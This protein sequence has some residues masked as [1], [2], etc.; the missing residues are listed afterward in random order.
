MKTGKEKSTMQAFD[1][2]AIHS[3]TAKRDGHGSL[4]MPVYDSAAFEFET[5]EKLEL[6]CRGK[7]FAHVYSRMS[8]P[9]V[10]DLE[11]RMQCLTRARGVIATSSGMAAIADA[12]IAI[13]E[14]GSNIVASRY[15]FG[16]SFSLLTTTLPELGITVKIADMTDPKGVAR[17]LDTGTRAIFL[18]SITNPQLEIADMRAITQIAG[19]AG[20]PVI[21]DGTL[22][23]PYVFRSKDFGVAVEVLSSTKYISGGATSLGGLIIDNGNFDWSLSPKLKEHTKR[24]GPMAFLSKLKREVARNLGACL[25]PHNAYLQVLGLET[26]VLRVDRSCATSLTIAN[27]LQDHPKVVAVNYP[28]LSSSPFHRIAGQQFG[29]KYGGILTFDLDSRENC[30]RV[31]NALKLIKRATTIHD[32]RTLALHPASSIYCEYTTD[33][34]NQLQ[35]RDTLIRLAV[36]IEDAADLLADLKQGL[37]IL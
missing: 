2:K 24:S 26:L 4:R 18:E 11:Q 10:E 7:Q 29:D 34:L 21:M 20:V 35:V 22:T 3:S 32:N 31:L 37:E 36:G 27:F 33:Q 19:D 16:H 9:T 30:Y 12:L 5:C 14:T 25:A 15:L 8:N 17:L 28:G 13:A 1:T 6:A 23:T